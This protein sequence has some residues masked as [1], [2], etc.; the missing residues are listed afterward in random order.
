MVSASKCTLPY[1][2]EAEYRL[3]GRIQTNINQFA[4]KGTRRHTN[5]C[6]RKIFYNQ[7]LGNFLKRINMWNAR[8]FPLYLL[9]VYKRSTGKSVNL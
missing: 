7:A 4:A 1:F 6:T 8:S 2:M 3:V 9:L 5:A